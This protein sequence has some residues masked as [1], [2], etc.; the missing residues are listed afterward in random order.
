MII[1]E[2]E[3]PRRRHLD[4]ALDALPYSSHSDKYQIR[5]FNASDLY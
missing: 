3:C 1:P 4:F 5:E 2:P